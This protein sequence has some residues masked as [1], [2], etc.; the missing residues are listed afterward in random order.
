MEVGA[1]DVEVAVWPGVVV[2]PWG[3]T[4]VGLGGVAFAGVVGVAAGLPGTGTKAEGAVVT[5]RV[6][7]IFVGLELPARSTRAAAS[8]PSE[9]TITA[10]IPAIGSRQFGVGA[11]RVR[12]A[13]PQRRH[14][15]C[16]A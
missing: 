12:A 4:G 6:T 2:L 10:T 13:A 3:V 9:S 8:T 5:M 14:Q 7:R 16:S 11:R 15:S 1:G